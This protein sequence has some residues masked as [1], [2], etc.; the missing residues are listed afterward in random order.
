M[1]ENY[2]RAIFEDPAFV[3]PKSARG[4]STKIVETEYRLLDRTRKALQIEVKIPT[5]RLPL[6]E[7]L[8]AESIG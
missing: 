6:A 2:K 7:G 5:A 1:P 4:V 8:E 3:S